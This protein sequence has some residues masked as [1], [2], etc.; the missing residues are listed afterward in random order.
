MA[1]QAPQQ[2]P[3]GGPLLSGAGAQQHTQLHR[4]RRDPTH[5]PDLRF[6][7]QQLPP[8]RFGRE[9]GAFLLNQPERHLQRWIGGR[10]GQY[11]LGARAQQR[12]VHQPVAAAVGDHHNPFVQ[13]AQHRCHHADVL[14]V[15]GETI[16]LDEIAHRVVV[17][18]QDDQARREVAQQALEH[19]GQGAQQGAASQPGP[20]GEQGEAGDGGHGQDEQHQATG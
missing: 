19:Q 16:D 12:V 3:L 8:L 14:H 9:G 20:G 13:A 1:H 10:Q 15:S 6:R 4:Q 2:F 5:A 18:E 11:Q 7:Q 17:V